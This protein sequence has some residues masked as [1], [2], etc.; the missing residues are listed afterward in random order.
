M[1]NQLKTAPA[2]DQFKGEEQDNSH[3]GKKNWEGR[4]KIY[5]NK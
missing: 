1:M 4:N 5:N 2:R 3:R